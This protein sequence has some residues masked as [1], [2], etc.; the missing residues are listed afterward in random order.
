MTINGWRFEDLQ[1]KPYAAAGG[2]AWEGKAVP[3]KMLW[4]GGAPYFV[5]SDKQHVN[6][7]VT[8]GSGCGK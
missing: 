2:A 4:T 3:G 8:P 6:I 1:G 5:N 7:H